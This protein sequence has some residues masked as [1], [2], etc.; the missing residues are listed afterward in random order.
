MKHLTVVLIGIGVTVFA[1]ISGA[2]ANHQG[3]DCSVCHDDQSTRNLSLIRETINT[4]NSGPKEVWFTAYEGWRSFA[5]GDTV[6]DGVCEVCHTLT[7]YH[8][9]DGDGVDHYDGTKCTV[10]H[11]HSEDFLRCHITC[12]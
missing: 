5:D 8:T 2:D 10:C 7:S 1:L 6:Y 9:N 12:I 3:F 4:P 11:P